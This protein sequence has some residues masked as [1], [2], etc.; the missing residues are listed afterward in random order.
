MA[1]GHGW[2]SVDREGSRVWKSR[3][4]KTVGLSRVGAEDGEDS[5]TPYSGLHCFSFFFGLKITEI[6]SLTVLEPR[7]PK[8][9]PRSRSVLRENSFPFLAPSSFLGL[10][11]HH[12]GLCLHGHIAFFSSVLKAPTAFLLQGRIR[13]ISPRTHRLRGVLPG[14]LP[15]SRPLAD[16]RLQR[17]LFQIR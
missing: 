8:S 12:S 10:W 11:P 14:S 5:Q 13:E 3:P 16:S 17:P 9:V 1:G 6:Y 7:D 15:I 4:E 2:T